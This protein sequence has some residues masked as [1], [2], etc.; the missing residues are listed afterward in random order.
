MNVMT[1]IETVV[2]K[3]EWAKRE[4]AELQRKCA[5]GSPDWQRHETIDERLHEAVAAL[6]Q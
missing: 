5:P 1:Q 3:L 2:R 4:N 6:G